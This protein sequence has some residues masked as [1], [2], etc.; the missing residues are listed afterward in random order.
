M[1]AVCTYEATR[2]R[3]PTRGRKRKMNTAQLLD[4][5]FY[6]CQTGCQ[7]SHLPVE[8]ASYKTTTTLLCGQRHGYLKTCSIHLHRLYLRLEVVPWF[9]IRVLSKMCMDVTCSA[10]TQQI[11]VAKLLS[12]LTDSRGTPLCAVLHRANKNDSLTLKHTLETFKRKVP[13][14]AN[15]SSLLAD[16][17]Y[18]AA[19]CRSACECHNLT[20][21]IPRRRTKEIYGGRYVVEQ[22]FG[23][24]DQFRRVRVRYEKL[25]RNFKSMHFL[26]LSAIVAR[27]L[28]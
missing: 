15:F 25:A 21:C 23:L 14:H 18:D 19:H 27:R 12:L 20:P 5:I 8:G 26:A 3:W 7:W 10:R 2:S 16:K 22:T 4:R 24:L 6:I 28:P 9:L 1:H 17:G 11:E 13:S